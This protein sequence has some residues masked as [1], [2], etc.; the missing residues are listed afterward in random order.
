MAATEPG[1]RDVV[2]GFLNLSRNLGLITG[3]S[4]MGAVFAFAAGITDLTHAPRAAIAV[5]T[6]TAFGVAAVLVGAA[7][8][9]AAASAMGIPK[10]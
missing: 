8:V 3:A 9:L 2:A 1:Q 4:A 5:G 6:H 7:L 10:H